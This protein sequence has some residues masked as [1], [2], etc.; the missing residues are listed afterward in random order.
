MV[1]KNC[2]HQCRALLSI[3]LIAS[4]LNAY[5]LC[6]IHPEKFYFYSLLSLVTVCKNLCCFDSETVQKISFQFILLTTHGHGRRT[7]RCRASTRTRL[8]TLTRS[9]HPSGWRHTPTSTTSIAELPWWSKAVRAGVRR[10][11]A[12]THATTK[13]TRIPSTA[14][15]W[16]SSVTVEQKFY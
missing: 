3:S 7:R 10:R 12:T 4:T 15:A 13:L 16:G 2:M 11:W 6:Y 8:A 9:R 1:G 14:E 5:I